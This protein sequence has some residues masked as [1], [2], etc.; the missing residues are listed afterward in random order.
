MLHI[1]AHTPGD[2]LL[3]ATSTSS[4]VGAHA[5]HRR[6]GYFGV[7]LVNKDNKNEAVVKITLKNG[8]IGATGKRFDYGSAQFD[9]G[10]PLAVTP[11]S[12]TGNEF[13]IT[14][15]PYSITDILLPDHNQ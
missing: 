12:A 1:V 5:T 4:M 7:M 11:F 6:D 8:S 13:T 14:L 3:D 10:T 9:A 2:A 15:A